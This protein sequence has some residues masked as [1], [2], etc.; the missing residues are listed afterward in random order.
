MIYARSAS[1]N[2]NI[3]IKA[4]IHRRID[5][6][7]NG[8]AVHIACTSPF[9]SSGKRFTDFGDG[10]QCIDFGVR[11]GIVDKFNRRMFSLP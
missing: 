9:G 2:H 4:G 8:I 7:D 6:M 5:G 3:C 1:D 11:P 10:A